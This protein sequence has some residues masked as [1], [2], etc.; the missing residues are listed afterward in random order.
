MR[1]NKIIELKMVGVDKGNEAT[2]LMSADKYDFIMA[3]GDDITDEDMFR[4]LPPESITI[5]VGSISDQAR[6]SLSQ[7]DTVKFLSGIM[8]EK[9]KNKNHG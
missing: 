2:R 9:N 1:G 6:F 5:K 3:M 4:A 8:S 7:T